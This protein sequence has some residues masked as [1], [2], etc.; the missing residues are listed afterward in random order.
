[1]VIWTKGC[2]HSRVR[3]GKQGEVEKIVVDSMSI[4]LDTHSKDALCSVDIALNKQTDPVVKPIYQNNESIND[5]IDE[6]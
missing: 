4:S 5:E 2:L 6:S 1:M 3:L